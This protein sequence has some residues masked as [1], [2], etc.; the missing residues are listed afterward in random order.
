MISS[1]LFK[2]GLQ[3]QVRSSSRKLSSDIQLKK[4]TCFVSMAQKCKYICHI[5]ARAR[6]FDKTSF[7]LISIFIFD[8][9]LED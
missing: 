6:P 2:F 3:F 9:L 7:I 8:N 4:E 1:C 5:L